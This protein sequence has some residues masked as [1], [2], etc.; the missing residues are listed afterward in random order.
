MW[1]F[2][3]KDPAK[4]FPYELGEVVGQ[5][6]LENKSVWTLHTGK[7][8]TSG[9]PVSIFVCDSKSGAS[10]TQLDVARSAVK[11]LKTLR[12]PSV[13]TFIAECDSPTSVL[14]ATEPVSPLSEHLGEILDRGPKR[15]YYLAWGIFQVCRALA[16]LNNDAKLKHNNINSASVFVT[17]AGDWKLAGLEYVC[18]A[19]AQP[20]AKI[21]PCLE[22][23]DPPER[24]DQS[25]A[26]LATAWAADIWGL[27]CLIWEVYNGYLNTMDQLGRLG[28]IPQ[29]LQSAYKECVG[30]NPGKRPSPQDVITKLR[31]S[32][33][34]FK[35]DL[36][37]IVLF[38]EEMQIKEE[39]DKSRFFTSLPGLLDNC[40]SNVCQGKI[41]PQ[42]INAF[43]FGGAGSAILAPVFKIGKELDTQEFQT[44]IVPCIVKLFS[45]ND[46]NARFKLL[47]QMENFVE[48]LSNKIVNDQVFPK[49]ESGFLDTEPLI[50]EKTVISM[51]HLA[52]KLSY[53]NLDEVVV[54]K[55]F[56]RL[57]RDEQGGIR[58]NTIVCLG[59]IAR[60][61]HPKT[62]QQA[63]LAC[64]SRGLKDP[65]P[66][67]RIAS[68]NAIAATQQF[69]TVQET[70]SRVLPVLAPATVDPEKAVRE[71]ALRVIRGF[72]GKLEKV[73][74]DPSLAEEMDKEVGSTNSAATAAAVAAA[75]WASWAVG[76]V[77]AKF[78]K[79][80]AGPAAPGGS[81]E[82][83]PAPEIKPSKPSEERPTEPSKSSKP[84]PSKAASAAI[85]SVSLTEK[86]S[87]NDGWGDDDGG[88]WDDPDADADGDWGSLEEPM[89]PEKVD[90]S[91]DWLG[92]FNSGVKSHSASMS[93][94]SGVK[95]HSALS[96]ASP[97]ESKSSDSWGNDW[98]EV[99]TN[100]M[101]SSDEARKRREEKKAERQKEIEAKRA[102]KKGPMKLGTKKNLD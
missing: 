2:L 26:R 81:Q 72:L 10:N 4:D 41:L 33:G 8:R 40:P 97:V 89:K 21:L 60:H 55:H 30:A 19:D 47:S 77:T 25:K 92:S 49:I 85:A 51:I 53:S 39:G 75:G 61:L 50:R 83:T 13:L 64:F 24:K 67:S 86:A 42:L 48:H 102:A 17:R 7:H 27:G 23:Y 70:G 79:S 71:Q 69:Y 65:F 94:N 14:L 80:P 43:E 45:S 32:P 46:R 16:F 96:P 62:R 82:S 36:I 11:R 66:P 58:T 15:E 12:H 76:A 28:D 18:A 78:Y 29:A 93:F 35:N 20:P 6:A 98:G 22:K 37:D 100:S 63:L 5:V 68:I 90:N 31:R 52:P 73:S 9:E 101:G 74:E 3:S 57:A 95:S 99:N 88:G 54:L 38:L 87:L 1:G 44:K 91:D 34:F 56:V 84:D 59:K